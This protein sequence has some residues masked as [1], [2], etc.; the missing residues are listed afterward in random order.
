MNSPRNVLVLTLLAALAGGCAARS[1]T[2]G[3]SPVGGDQATSEGSKAI[4][5]GSLASSPAV[6]LA[7]LRRIYD[8]RTKAIDG[9]DYPIG[10]GDMIEISVP[11]M[12]ELDDET[13]RVTSSGTVSLPMLGDIQAAGLTEKQFKTELRKALSQY[14]HRPHVAVHVTEYRSRQV[15]VLGAVD[16]PGLYTVKNAQATILDMISE[17]GGLTEDATQRLLFIPVDR[18]DPDE[19]ESFELAGL[20]SADTQRSRL[21]KDLK[22]PLLQAS[23]PI[24]IDL[25]KM[26]SRSQRFALAVPVRPGDT[27]MALGGGQVFVQGWV[28]SPGALKMTRGLTLLG[29]IAA[30]GGPSFPAKKSQVQILRDG[31][32]TDR[33]VRTVDISD[34][35]DG[36]AEDIALREGDIILVEAQG[37]KLVAYGV[38]RFFSE[39]MRVGVSVASPF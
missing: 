5:A 12:P 1:N 3:W 22:E 36:K 32:G 2:N 27:I 37:G 38:Y 39:V 25:D 7:R 30:A 19:V 14:M 10:T 33:I 11:A 13:V 18:V 6:D 15:G 34:I 28:E 17:A 35:E 20:V 31:G 23:D 16:D 24:I 4:A 26:N 21:S 29:A 8:E 9:Y